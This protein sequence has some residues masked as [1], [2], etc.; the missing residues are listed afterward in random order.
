M[1]LGSSCGFNVYV[2]D[3][4]GNN[5]V[6]ESTRQVWSQPVSTAHFYT[7]AQ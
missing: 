4:D 2:S 7:S 3:F 5:A 6:D 1:G